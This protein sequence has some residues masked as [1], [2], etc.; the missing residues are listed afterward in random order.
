MRHL[1]ASTLLLSFALLAEGAAPPVSMRADDQL[2][3]LF[4]GSDRPVLI[5][6]H[7]R[8]G[9]KPYLA[10]WNEFMDKLFAWFDRDNDGFLSPTEVT[11]LPQPMHIAF[12]AQGAKAW[13]REQ[14]IPLS[15]IDTNKDG[16]VSKEE[17]RA[18]YRRKGFPESTFVVQDYQAAQAKQ[19]NDAIVKR[20]DPKGGGK[21]TAAKVASLYEKLRALDQ[22]DD[23]IITP[24]EL[25]NDAGARGIYVSR[26]TSTDSEEPLVRP[27][28][29]TACNRSSR[30]K[31]PAW[32]KPSWRSMT[33]TRTAG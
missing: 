28:S 1:F 32:S 14:S 2:D 30:G 26:R 9:D 15:T 7:V 10:P 20:L 29:I 13:V 19:L 25:D 11:R 8:V 23:E 5:R 24:A 27:S 17:F 33:A 12:I 3:Y 4:L 21:L 18:Y 22:N 31:K 6:F 16:K